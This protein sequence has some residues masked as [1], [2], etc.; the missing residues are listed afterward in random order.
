MSGARDSV[1]LEE[2]I[3]E[4]AYEW[5]ARTSPRMLEAIQNEL[6]RGRSPL[7]IRRLVSMHVGPDR[8]GLALRCY[9][10]AIYIAEY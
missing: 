1:T 8:A 4:D 7:E 9:Q 2:A 10:A 3:N 5:L 6:S